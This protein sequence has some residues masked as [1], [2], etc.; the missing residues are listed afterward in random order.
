MLLWTYRYKFMCGY[1][2]IYL[3]WKWNCLVML[4]LCLALFRNCQVSTK[5]ATIFTFWH[6]SV[7]RFWFLYILTII[8]YFSFIY[9]II[10]ALL[11]TVK[12]YLIVVLM[13]ILSDDRWCVACFHG[14]IG[15]LSVLQRNVHSNALLIFILGCLF[16]FAW[17]NDFI[18]WIQVLC[19][20]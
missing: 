4:I 3:G 19:L 20:M 15:H 6:C 12:W 8:G 11:M 13:Y 5:V 9:I 7:W 10:I 1:V 18:F 17:K 14:I 16:N 2:F